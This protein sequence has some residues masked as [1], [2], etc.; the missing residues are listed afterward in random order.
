[1]VHSAFPAS[2]NREKKFPMGVPDYFEKPFV[3]SE[4]MD[5]VIKLLDIKK[6]V[7]RCDSGRLNF[8]GGKS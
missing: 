5:R 1:M 6:D 7:F 4:L 3:A 2:L 8:K